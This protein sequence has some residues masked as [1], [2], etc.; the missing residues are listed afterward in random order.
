VKLKF[1][2][3]SESRPLQQQQL[4]L[5]PSVTLFLLS[6]NLPSLLLPKLY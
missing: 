5:L 2:P 3:K 1:R 6:G 4:L